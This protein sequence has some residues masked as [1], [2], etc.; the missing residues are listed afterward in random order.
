MEIQAETVKEAQEAYNSMSD[1]FDEFSL[2]ADFL[3]AKVQMKDSDKK[4][5][6]DC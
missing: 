3:K 1:D 2:E 4:R 6:I 5:W